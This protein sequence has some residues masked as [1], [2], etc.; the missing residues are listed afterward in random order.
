M[1]RPLARLAERIVFRTARAQRT[2]VT[3]SYLISGAV[4]WTIRAVFGE[5]G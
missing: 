5:A 4:I 3:L 1:L 2:L